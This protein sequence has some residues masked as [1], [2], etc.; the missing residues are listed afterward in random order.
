MYTNSSH[1]NYSQM[2][3]FYDFVN[4][5]IWPVS[6]RNYPDSLTTVNGTLLQS[7]MAGDNFTT[8]K[9]TVNSALRVSSVYT[10]VNVPSM[11]ISSLPINV[12]QEQGNKKEQLIDHAVYWLL[13][14]EPNGYMTAA[15]F[16]LAMMV[17]VRSWGNAFAYINRDSRQNPSSLDIWEPW[18]VTIH[19]SEGK[20]FYSYDGGEMIPARNV[21]HY[22]FFSFD[23]I[24]GVNPIHQNA[25]TIGQAIRLDRYQS[26]IT[27]ARPPGILSYEGNLSPEQKSQNKK[28][29][30]DG[31]RDSVKV[32][33]GRWHYDAIMTQPEAAQFVQAKAGIER[34]IYGIWQLPPSFAQ[35]LERGTYNNVEQGDLGYAKHTISPICTNIEKEN[36]MKLFFEKEKA[37][38]YTKFNMNGLLR[39]DLAAR[40]AFYQSMI[41]IGLMTRNEGRSLED[42]DPY[43]GGDV[44]LVQGAMIPGDEEGIKSLRKKM[45]T[46]VIPSVPQTKLNG[47]AIYQ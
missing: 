28:E 33:S 29:F 42:L 3:A 40:Q 36:N 21:L 19:K 22:R 35:N 47:H 13:S 1:N 10:C 34:Q 23:G 24:C 45:E 30:Q 32:L 44:P 2:A 41:N 43:D 18:K 20:L 31:S 11:T 14:Q 16:W 15:N 39:G 38:T 26:L 37:T 7:I 6:S 25:N 46:E 12:V 5:Y 17:N 27:G 8:E 4:K 9:V